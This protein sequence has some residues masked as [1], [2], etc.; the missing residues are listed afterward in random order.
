[1]VHDDLTPV[2]FR[3]R[4]PWRAIDH[5]MLTTNVNTVRNRLV[6]KFR[7]SPRRASLH[8]VQR[9][10]TREWFEA[11]HASRASCATALPKATV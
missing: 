7:A 2:T 3:V 10:A 11:K 5:D 4:A 9:C 1:M 6:P 8:G